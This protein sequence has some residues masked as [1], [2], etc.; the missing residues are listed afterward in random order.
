MRWILENKEWLFSGV[1][2]LVVVALIN[3]FF[4]NKKGKS[5]MSS[6][7]DVNVRGD[8]RAGDGKD[9]DGGDVRIEGG[10]GGSEGSGGNATIGPGT[11]RA[12]D[13]GRGGR[14][15]NFVIKGGDGGS[16][17]Q[18]QQT[19]EFANLDALWNYVKDMKPGEQ[20]SVRHAK[21][22]AQG[23]F[24]DIKDDQRFSAFKTYTDIYKP[25]GQ[26]DPR[27]FIIKRL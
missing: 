9:A 17:M 6:G 22:A 2:G 14:G 8:M 26:H 23:V 12:G 10:A 7:G 13:G 3:L 15:G 4:R 27:T 18:N 25:H 5:Q 21:Q 24:N 1:G 16:R 19:F 11:Y 20:R